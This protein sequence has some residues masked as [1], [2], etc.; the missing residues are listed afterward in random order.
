MYQIPFPYRKIAI[1]GNCV[2]YQEFGIKKIIDLAN[3]M[4]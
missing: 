4:I 1:I 2:P 3:N